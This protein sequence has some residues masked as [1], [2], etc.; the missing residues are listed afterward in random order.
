M[1][2]IKKI[3]EKHNK[4]IQK[5]DRPFFIKML[6]HMFPF[7]TFGIPLI[8]GATAASGMIDSPEYKDVSFI[9][10]MFMF[11]T[12]L[13]FLGLHDINNVE[14]NMKDCIHVL[15]FNI[16]LSYGTFFAIFFYHLL[17]H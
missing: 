4:L 11:S 6:I 5:L 12:T 3:R 1:K 8:F 9:L 16:I 14:K 15:I 2:I 7:V 13:S 10:K 17:F